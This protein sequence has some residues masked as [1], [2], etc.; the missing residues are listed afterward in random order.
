[1]PLSSLIK[2]IKVAGSKY[3]KQEELFPNFS[4][5]QDGYA[6]FTYSIEAKDTLIE[7]VKNQEEHH[8]TKSYVEELKELLEAHNVEF[9]PKY[10]N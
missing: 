8:S 1:M 7:Y 4:N 10:L 3:I 9:D 6:A 5:W 2:D